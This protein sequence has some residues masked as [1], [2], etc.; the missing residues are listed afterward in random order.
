LHFP[1]TAGKT[2]HNLKNKIIKIISLFIA[3]ANGHNFYYCGFYVQTALLGSKERFLN[4]NSLHLLLEF[5]LPVN[6]QNA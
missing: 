5:S 1:H 6:T 4:Y 3:L 2:S